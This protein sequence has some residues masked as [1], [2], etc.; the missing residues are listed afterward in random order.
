MDARAPH[1][2]ERMGRFEA[3]CVVGWLVLM[4]L[5][6]FEVLGLGFPVTLLLIVL[7]GRPLVD[8]ARAAAARPRE[9]LR[10][11]AIVTVLSFVAGIAS[12]S[13]LTPVIASITGLDLSESTNTTQWMTRLWAN[14][15]WFPVL[16]L[17]GPLGEEL[18]CR[19]GIFRLVSRLNVLLAHLVTAG[20]FGLQHVVQA[21]LHGDPAQLWHIPGYALTSL[22]WTWAYRRTGNLMVPFG[23]H[24]LVN[25]IPLALILLLS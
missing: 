15:W 9:I 12:Q 16:T 7:L 6:R 4:L 25:G 18:G 24:A 23:A 10:W 5:A 3:A 2:D 20:L 11:V 13:L 17:F 19:Y 14:P 1:Y 8:A 21:W 22:V